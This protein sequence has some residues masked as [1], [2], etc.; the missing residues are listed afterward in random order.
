MTE[1]I[2]KYFIIQ[3]ISSALMVIIVLIILETNLLKNFVSIII[4]TSLIIKLA[5]TPFHQWII[6][7]TK[8][9]KIINATILITWQKIL[10][11]YL[12]FFQ[13]KRII[14]V[15]IL[16]TTLAGSLP[17]INKNKILEIIAISSVFN[18]RWTLAALT[19]GTKL[20][21]IFCIFYWNSVIITIWI[22][23]TLNLKTLNREKISKSNKVTTLF[24]ISNL[25]GIPPFSSFLAKWFIAIE[26][27]KQRLKGTLTYLLI[28]RTIR[29]FIYLRITLKIISS[30]KSD[31]LKK[32]NNI[33]IAL[34]IFLLISLAIPTLVWTL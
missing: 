13:S 24:I 34:I 8:K 26:I 31:T 32:L 7:L 29:F 5:A 21:F 9:S 33:K 1:T 11:I 30:K 20:I 3:S 12:I 17:Q 28:I 25:A 4:I 18:L 14:I 10:P 6:E 15:F 27:N 16:S 2:I 22:L 19:I 23:K